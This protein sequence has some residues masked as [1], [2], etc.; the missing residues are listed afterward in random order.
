MDPAHRQL[1]QQNRIF[2]ISNMANPMQVADLL[3]ERDVL[4][5]GMRQEIE[6]HNYT[7]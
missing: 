6:V 2:I 4:T 5:E 1:L 3:F 7:E